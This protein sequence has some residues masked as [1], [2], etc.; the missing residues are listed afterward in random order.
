M[1]EITIYIVQRA[2]TTEVHKQELLFLCFTCH[3][4][5]VNISVKFD[6]NISQFSSGHEYMTEI[7]IYIVQWAVTP[8]VGKPQL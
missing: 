2:V 5:V 4:M 3:L 6:E 7:I 1:S 8:R